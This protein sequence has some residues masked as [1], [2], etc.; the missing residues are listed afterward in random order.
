M[1]YRWDKAQTGADTRKRIRE[2]DIRI[3]A[4]EAARR[5]ESRST[6]KQ[7]TPE[8]RARISPVVV[9]EISTTA[10]TDIRR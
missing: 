8:A 6:A 2:V 5:T 3:H 9:R 1:L 4:S 10:A 7:S